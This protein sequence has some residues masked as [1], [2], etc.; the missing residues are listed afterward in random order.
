MHDG[1]STRLFVEG[2][3]IWLARTGR[4][5]GRGDQQQ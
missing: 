4:E 5:G 2:L 3:V 1:D